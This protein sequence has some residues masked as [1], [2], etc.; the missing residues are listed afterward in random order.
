MQDELELG[1]MQTRWDRRFFESTRGRIVTLLR[2]R[3]HTVDEL[4]KQ[5]DLTDNAIRAHLTAL[6]RDGIVRQYGFRRGA[7][8]PAFDYDLTDDAQALFANAY[9]P[10]LRQLLAVLV[11]ELGSQQT[12]TLFR[13]AGRQLAA[14][15]PAAHGDTRQRME[16]AVDLLGRLGGLAELEE[17]DDSL[18]IRGYSCPLTGIVADQPEVCSLVEA[19]LTEYVGMPVFEQCNR[20]ERPRCQFEVTLSSS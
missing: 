18:T 2:R 3:R 7:G 13:R 12:E 11:D 14:G 9:K 10:V 1:F 4:A 19:L 17:A 8:K 16:A 6:E 20:G 5:L 15:F